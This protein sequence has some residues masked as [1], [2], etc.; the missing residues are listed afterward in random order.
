M[1][2]M[3]FVESCDQDLSS[4]TIQDINHACKLRTDR[5]QHSQKARRFCRV[6]WSP[7]MQIP[8]ATEVA[9]FRKA[10]G[11]SFVAAGQ[12]VIHSKANLK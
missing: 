2:V 8:K 9:T 6:F 7:Q 3:I 11:L 5:Q 12:A 10:S 1:S 4:A